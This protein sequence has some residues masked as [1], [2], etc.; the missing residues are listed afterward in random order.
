MKDELSVPI[1]IGW[2]AAL[3]IVGGVAL[4]AATAGG[5]PQ[6]RR[7]PAASE[8]PTAAASQEPTAPT[9]TT[10]PDAPGDEGAGAAG[11]DEHPA[12]G[13]DVDAVAAAFAAAMV[14]VDAATD[15]GPSA[16]VERAT[17]WTTPELAAELQA[18]QVTSGASWWSELQAHGGATTAQVKPV[19]DSGQ[20]ED[21]AT[22]A[23]RVRWVERLAT[24]PDGWEGEPYGQTMF[25]T[26]TRTD[27]TAAWLVSDVTVG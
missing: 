20:P 25:I 10:S 12:S 9:P 27:A 4:W 17:R 15:T 6:P 3:I 13:A 11:G 19:E 1:V 18:A 7:T 14:E 23:Y 21:T 16:A 22:T 8:A 5:S 24:A 26:L 2:V